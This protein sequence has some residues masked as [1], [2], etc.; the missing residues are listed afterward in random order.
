MRTCVTAFARYCD[1]VEVN[2]GW[3]FASFRTSGSGSL[4]PAKARS[5]RS[6]DMP[7]ALAFGHMFWMK[8]SNSGSAE[9]SGAVMPKSPATRTAAVRY[10]SLAIIAL[11]PRSSLSHLDYYN[12]SGKKGSTDLNLERFPFAKVDKLGREALGFAKPHFQ[13]KQSSQS[14]PLY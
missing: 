8:P 4:I 6:R 1:V 13:T 12:P 11:D 3:L 5:N 9:A 2:S 7:A 10:L 14:S